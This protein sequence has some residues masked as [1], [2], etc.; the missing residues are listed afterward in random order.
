M[1]IVPQSAP[2]DSQ[3]NLLR[4]V[5]DPAGT[6]WRPNEPFRMRLQLTGQKHGM[7]SVY[8][9]WADSRRHTYPMFTTS[10]VALLQSGLVSKGIST[11]WWIIVK[12]GQ[13]FGISPWSNDSGVA[14]D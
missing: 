13:Y 12:N 7:G 9:E 5:I 3:G 8:V 14:S 2:Y 10:L 4:H 6:Q 11:G 1:T